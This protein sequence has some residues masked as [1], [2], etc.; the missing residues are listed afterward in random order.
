MNKLNLSFFFHLSECKTL[1]LRHGLSAEV[2][3]SGEV[4][5]PDARFE[6]PGEESRERKPS[7]LPSLLLRTGAAAY[8]GSN[9]SDSI[10]VAGHRVTSTSSAVTLWA[11]EVVAAA[12]TAT[13]ASFAAPAN[14]SQ[15]SSIGHLLDLSIALRVVRRQDVIVRGQFL[16][17]GLYRG[18][19]RPRR[20]RRKQGLRPET[21]EVSLSRDIGTPARSES[22]AIV[23]RFLPFS[24]L[25]TS[26]VCRHHAID[27]RRQA[28]AELKSGGGGPGGGG[29]N[30]D[31]SAAQQRLLAAQI[32]RTS[33]SYHHVQQS[34]SSATLS[35]TSS[36]PLP[37]ASS[38]AFSVHHYG[39]SAKGEKN[40]KGSL[41]RGQTEVSF[42]CHSSRSLLFHCQ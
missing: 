32:G 16:T 18:N 25:T 34:S 6:F 31:A 2:G 11:G 30:S 8:G 14:L 23:A 24:F 37:M 12:V 41:V 26:L 15:F 27:I 35:S 42:G 5:A 40:M 9:S 1:S 13:A 19:R 21:G 7:F 29:P 39:V 38:P 3:V 36:L 4:G 10:R 28:A 22:F 20:R 17:D 33:V